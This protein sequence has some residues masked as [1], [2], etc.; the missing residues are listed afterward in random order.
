MIFHELFP[1][2]EIAWVQAPYTLLKFLLT[3]WQRDM[4]WCFHLLTHCVSNASA[5]LYNQFS[6][7]LSSS[8]LWCNTFTLPLSVPLSDQGSSP[9]SCCTVRLFDH[10]W[11]LTSLV[12]FLWLYNSLKGLFVFGFAEHLPLE[13]ERKEEPAHLL[14]SLVSLSLTS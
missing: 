6:P 12:L 8:L 5:L 3:R 14:C 4:R 9:P 13:D 10:H 2:L 11:S 1:T 7:L